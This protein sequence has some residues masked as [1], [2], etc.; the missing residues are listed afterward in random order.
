[1]LTKNARPI[2]MGTILGGFVLFVVLAAPLDYFV[3]GRRYRKYTWIVFPSLC[4]VFA[5]G[6]MAYSDHRFSRLQNTATCTV[7]DLGTDGRILRQTKYIARLSPTAGTGTHTADSALT[8]ACPA[9]TRYRDDRDFPTPTYTGNTGGATTVRAAWK[10][11]TPYF[12][13]ETSFPDGAEASGLH[14]D[15]WDPWSSNGADGVAV[16]VEG[17]SNPISRR[18]SI[19]AIITNVPPRP[20]STNPDIASEFLGL[21]PFA[22]WS[23]SHSTF[24]VSPNGNPV[25]LSDITITYADAEIAI[26]LALKTQGSEIRVYRRLYRQPSQP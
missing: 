6:L 25:D 5:W 26:L 9:D 1:M 3:L 22:G 24:R 2:P 20:L 14:W 12:F 10:K 19:T 18:G 7:V 11:W 8:V 21:E 13:R 4:C 17:W 15:A 23:S 16:G